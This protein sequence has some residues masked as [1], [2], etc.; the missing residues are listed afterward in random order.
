[1]KDT[2]CVDVNFESGV[3]VERGLAGSQRRRS[4]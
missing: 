4:S 2:P 3:C 1:M